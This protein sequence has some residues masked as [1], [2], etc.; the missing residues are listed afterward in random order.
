MK[1]RSIRTRRSLKPDQALLVGKLRRSPRNSLWAEP[2]L[3]LDVWCPYCKTDHNHGWGHESSR[4]DAVEHRASHCPGDG[5]LGT[6]QGYF[7]GLDPS[8]AEHNRR[9]LGEHRRFYLEWE[10]RQRRR[11]QCRNDPAN[12]TIPGVSS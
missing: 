3:Y 6:S 5:P 1:P 12:F 11:E 7:I 4:L 2:V 10:A 8:H 9:E